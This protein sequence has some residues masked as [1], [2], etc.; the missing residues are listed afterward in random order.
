MNPLKAPKIQ[1][2]VDRWFPERRFGFATDGATRYF[3][4]QEDILTEGVEEIEPGLTEIRG[5]VKEGKKSPRLVSVEVVGR[6]HLPTV[7]I[8]DTHDCVVI[9]LFGSHRTGFARPIGMPR[10]AENTCH[11]SVD[12]FVTTG[13]ETLKVGSMLSGVV[14]DNPEKG[15]CLKE[16]EVYRPEGQKQN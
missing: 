12:D 8:G 15:K 16:I 14:A 10:S 3:F 7:Q 6:A 11:F 13:E 2:L 4:C 1:C 9:S 5:A